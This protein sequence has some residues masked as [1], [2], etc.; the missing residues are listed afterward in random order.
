MGG[1]QVEILTEI[2]KHYANLLIKKQEEKRR[3]EEETLRYSDFQDSP[4]SEPAQT[5]PII[6]FYFFTGWRMMVGAAR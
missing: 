5:L 3:C 2:G 6:K 1:V 4:Q